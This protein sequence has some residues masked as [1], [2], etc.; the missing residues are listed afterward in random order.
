MKQ[1]VT[2][3]LIIVLLCIGII[4]CKNQKESQKATTTT[5]AKVAFDGVHDIDFKK[6]TVFW[7]GHKLIGSHT[8]SIELTSG[9]LIFDEGILKGGNFIA[10]MKSIKA[11]ELMDDGKEEEEEEEENGHDDRDDLANHLKDA[12]FFDANTYPEAKLTITSIANTTSGYT[13]QGNMTIKGQTHPVSFPAQI[14]GSIFKAT[15]SI[16]RTKYGIKYGSGSFFSNLGDNVIKDKFDIIVA[17][18]II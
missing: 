13:V 9:K 10:N 11:T 18:H 6:S 16:D 2:R 15:V 1:Q 14:E 4:A 8:G 12:D 17:L 3:G 5:S 7:K